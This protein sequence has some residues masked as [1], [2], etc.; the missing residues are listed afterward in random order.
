[1]STAT[2]REV[3]T[4]EDALAAPRPAEIVIGKDVLELV[5]SAMYV[6]PMTVYREYIQNAA[7]ALDDARR[8]GVI[9]SD[10]PGRVD[11]TIDAGSRTVRIRDNGVGLPWASFARTLT[12][13]G[14]SA[15]RGTDARGFRGVGR[16]A[17]LGYAQELVFRSK[18]AGEEKVSELRWDCR[19]LKTMLRSIDFDGDVAELISQVV[20][21]GRVPADDHPDRFFE[22][23]LRGIVRLRSDRLMTAA[24]VADYLAQVAPIPFSPDF[25]FGAEIAAAMR[26]A[27]SPADLHIHIDGATEPLHRPHRDTFDAGGGRRLAYEALEIL[28]VPDMDGGRA[29]LAWVLHHPY[30]GAIPAVNLVKGLRMR[31][32]NVQVGGGKILE[33]LFSEPRFNPWSVGEVHILDRR[34]VPNGRRDD[35][36][37]NAHLSNLLNQLSPVVRDIARRCRSNSIRRNWIRKFDLGDAAVRSAAEELANPGV[38][39]GERANATALAVSTLDEMTRIAA[40]PVVGD[41]AVG[42]AERVAA[43]RSELSDTAGMGAEQTPTPLAG[44]PARDREVYERVLELV[45]ECSGNRAT[46]RKLVE[47][48][49]AKLA[50]TAG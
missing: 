4:P 5:S 50:E 6:D 49:T 34:I 40:M 27:M 31:A 47:R 21:T 33:D 24:A 18:T 9:R 26:A 32:G 36:E 8:A 22:V 20:R 48:I 11:I 37:Q 30:E 14:G 17:G 44:L 25:S 13:I 35:F 10:E 38:A 16:L 28:E 43:L 45:I 42:M 15:K 41:D 23:E 12:A 46:A 1:M 3:A 39:K 2:I 29:A 19:R 7:D